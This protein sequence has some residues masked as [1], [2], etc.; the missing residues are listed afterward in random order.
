MSF[1]NKSKASLKEASESFEFT[2]L[3]RQFHSFPAFTMKKWS[4]EVFIFAT[5]E[6]TLGIVATLPLRK[7]SCHV[8]PTSFGTFSWRIFHAYIAKCIVLS[9]AV[10]TSNLKLQGASSS[11]GVECQQ[12]WM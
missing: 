4:H 11:Q 10:E 1:K 7:L 5:D 8:K 12:F 3:G 6:G 9:Y 2:A